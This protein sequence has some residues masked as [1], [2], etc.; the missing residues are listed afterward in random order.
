MRD[1]PRRRAIIKN[2]LKFHPDVILVYWPN[3]IIEDLNK[4]G[5]PIIQMLHMAPSFFLKDKKVS[6]FKESLKNCDSI[7][8]LLPN[9]IT[10]LRESVRNEHIVSI[11]NIVPQYKEQA[12]VSSH[13][14]IFIGRIA[15]QKRPWL[16]PQAFALIK[17]KYPDWKIELWGESNVETE[18]TNL[19]KQIIKENALEDT[20]RLCGTTLNVKEQLQRASIIL[21]PSQIEGFSLAMTEGMSMGLPVVACKDCASVDSIVHH[22]VNGMLCEPTPEDIAL[23]LSVL[24]DSREMRQKLGAQ[25]KEDMKHYSA[26]AVCK[27][28]ED[29][30]K[31]VIERKKQG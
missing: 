19:V 11:P 29:L 3:I 22:N 30:M 14:I 7:Q 17:D 10:M 31:T 25:A 12:D 4:L 8:V 1:L 13:T 6:L 23:H 26:D 2:I 20:V 21:M 15:N 28:W 16:I 24:M 9:Y 5:I 18:T 27:Q